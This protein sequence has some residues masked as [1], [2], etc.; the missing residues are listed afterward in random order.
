MPGGVKSHITHS[1]QR[2]EIPAK[3][4]CVY[5]IDTVFFTENVPKKLL[6]KS[7]KS[8]INKMPDV[9]H[10]QKVLSSTLSSAE[11]IC[12]IYCRLLAVRRL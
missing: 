4:I 11:N 1:E 5:I 12:L 6:Q 9:A 8:F 10:P 2:V 7:L 3:S